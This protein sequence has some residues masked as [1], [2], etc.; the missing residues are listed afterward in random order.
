MSSDRVNRADLRYSREND[1]WSREQWVAFSRLPGV[2]VYV[3]LDGNR[4]LE[5]NEI[6]NGLEKAL[7]SEGTV[8]LKATRFALVHSDDTAA[9]RADLDANLN[10]IRANFADVVMRRVEGRDTALIVNPSPKQSKRDAAYLAYSNTNLYR[11]KDVQKAREKGEEAVEIAARIYV[12]R[13]DPSHAHHC[14]AVYCT[15]TPIDT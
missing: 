11:L 14:S 10:T 3:D 6:Y 13:F 8:R 1:G 4:Y 12:S 2:S 15:I 5:A 9:S 7:E